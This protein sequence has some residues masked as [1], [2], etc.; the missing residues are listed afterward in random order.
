[1]IGFGGGSSYTA[2]MY[3][4]DVSYLD[5]PKVSLLCNLVVVS[6]SAFHFYK[7]KLFDFKM[8]L[9]LLLGSVPL[10][11]IGGTIK[12]NEKTFF[13]F[14]AFALLFS[15][16]CLLFKKKIDLKSDYISKKTLFIMG[17]L[18]GFVAGL[19]GIGGG[20]FL[21]PLLM[22]LGWLRP[23][24]SAA[25]ACLFILLNSLAGVLGQFIKTESFNLEN[26][27]LWWLLAVVLVGGQLGIRLG[28]KPQFSE[29]KIRFLTAVLTLFVSVR[30]F[31]NI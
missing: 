9:P 10:A 12:L 24:Q 20:I 2:L 7:E 14:L 13:L 5:I 27:R 15:G 30:I 18:L 16:L 21:S 19:V 28:V 31:L 3:L 1:M 23:K 11:F 29:E 6:G 22:N 25:L 26:T 17:S 8:A 4:F